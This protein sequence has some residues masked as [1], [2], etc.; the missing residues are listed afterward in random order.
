MNTHN[1]LKVLEETIEEMKELKDISK[2]VL[3]FKLTMQDIIG[4]LKHFNYIM[5]II[6]F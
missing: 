5:K 6:F 1:Y 3:F 2:D 4:Q